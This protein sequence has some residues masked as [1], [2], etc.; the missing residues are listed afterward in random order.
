MPASA[1]PEAAGP[2]LTLRGLEIAFPGIGPV[3]SVP[4]LTLADGA[5][6][7]I[8]GPSGA[9]KTSLLH[10]LAGLEA[11]T[12]GEVVWDDISIW[13]LP[14][15]ARERWRRTRIGLVFQDIHLI[16]GLS[17]L[18]NVLLPL[19]FDHLRPPPALRDRARGVLDE[20]GL[21]QPGRSVAVMSRGERQR[22][23]LARALLR[24]P[25]LLFADEP[26]ASLDRRA[27]DEVGRLLFEQAA[28]SGA[29]LVVV[30]HD[31]AL[32][33]HATTRLRLEAGT[34]VPA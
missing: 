2:A 1:S 33:A 23:A 24:R 28:A 29:T 31:P 12:R 20:L 22:V 4:E 26:T 9:G 7:A 21:A 6:I 18:E 5:L 11:P 14:R 16:D 8:E 10:A 32:L 3:V 27:G 19:N 15:A 34:L 13:A 17:A 30:S 25:A